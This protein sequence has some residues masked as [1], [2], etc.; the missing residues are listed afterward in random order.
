MGIKDKITIS[1]EEFI[2]ILKNQISEGER[3]L[4]Q[5]RSLGFDYNSG[6]SYRSLNIK[7][8]NWHESNINS[9]GKIL[10]DLLR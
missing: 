1:L 10:L 2:M 9:I 7:I 4:E 6:E 8:Q 5:V 3:L